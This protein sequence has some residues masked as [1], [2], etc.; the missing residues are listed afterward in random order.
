M[1]LFFKYSYI[2]RSLLVLKFISIFK[3]CIRN[4]LNFKYMYLNS[5]AITRTSPIFVILDVKLR[6]LNLLFVRWIK[7]SVHGLRT[8]L[9]GGVG[10]AGGVLLSRYILPDSA[11]TEETKVTISVLLILLPLFEWYWSFLFYANF[12]N[13]SFQGYQFRYG[14]RATAVLI[15]EGGGGTADSILWFLWHM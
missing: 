2:F 1:Y 11:Y 13:I 12:G 5:R 6:W 4:T 3:K 14:V 15:L 7:M 10:G 8:L 9:L